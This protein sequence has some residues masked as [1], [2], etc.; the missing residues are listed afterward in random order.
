MRHRLLIVDDY[1]SPAFDQASA[2]AVGGDRWDLFL[3]GGSPDWFRWRHP[4]QLR[5]LPGCRVVDAARLAAQAHASVG[6]FVVRLGATL[7]RLALGG[8]TL[9]ELLQERHGNAWWHLE[10]SEK[11]PYRGPLIGQLYRLAL[12]NAIAETDG[13]DE[14]WC[15]IRER[16][17]ADTLRAT[18]ETR[19]RW[20]MLDARPAPGPQRMEE[21]PLLRHSLIAARALGRFLSIHVFTRWLGGRAKPPRTGSGRWVFSVFPTWWADAST[22]QPRDRFLTNAADARLDGYFVWL[23]QP[24]V[25]WR[26]TRAVRDACASLHLVPLQRS[27]SL[28]DLLTVLSPRYFRRVLRFEKTMRPHLHVPFAGCDVGHLVGAEISRSLSAHEPLQNALVARALAKAADTVHPRLL[29]YRG[30]SQPLESA[31]LQGLAGKAKAIGFHHFPY[32]ERHLP[33][34]FTPQEVEESLQQ[35]PSRVARPLPDGIVALGPALAANVARGGFPKD[36]VVVCGP[37]RYGPLFTYRRVMAPRQAIRRR[38]GLAADVFLIIVALAI[39]ESDTEALFGSLIGGCPDLATLRVIIRTHPNRPHGDDALRGAIDALGQARAELMPVSANMY[40]YVAAAS[41]MVC[42]GSM[43][44][45]EAIV[46]GIMPIVMDNPSTYGAVSLA[47]YEE[48]MFIVHNASELGAAI[49]HV[50]ENS[51]ECRRKREAWPAL[52]EQ[53]FGDSDQ[54]LGAQLDRAL[55]VF[56]PPA[57]HPCAGTVTT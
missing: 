9:F 36:R 27:L 28:W 53:V 8:E 37:Q 26:H 16:V 46:L 25:L 57:S 32:A 56:D 52:I 17:L 18:L 4:E 19:P 12:L 10:A 33:M 38:L 55:D 41:C 24:A 50:R 7:P 29:L 35:P 20:R 40:D 6:E 3:L 47:Q 45:F 15:S 5:K 39:V 11:G 48:G 1:S 13:Y 14:V 34:Q 44:A 30:E 43:I 49:Q 21:R 51:D 22:S 2:S 23:A 31:L 54:P 42:V